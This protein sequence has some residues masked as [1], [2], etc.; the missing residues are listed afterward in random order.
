MRPGGYP[1]AP[2]QADRLR[3]PGSSVRGRSLFVPCTEVRPRTAG[4]RP[5][6]LPLALVA[7][8]RPISGVPPGTETKL[9]LASEIH[10]TCVTHTLRGRN[11]RTSRRR[12]RTWRWRCTAWAAVWRVFQMGNNGYTANVSCGV[13]VVAC[14]VLPSSGAVSPAVASPSASASPSRSMTSSP[15]AS[16]ASVRRLRAAFS[17]RS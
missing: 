11:A 13:T 9:F 4:Q 14:L 6:V 3:D 17:F 7:R 1:I 8:R 10:E 12:S 16:S 2:G 5:P 15:T